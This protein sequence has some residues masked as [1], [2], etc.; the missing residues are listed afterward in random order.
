MNYIR[1]WNNCKYTHIIHLV[2]GKI[3]ATASDV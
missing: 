3:Y 2:N 1:I